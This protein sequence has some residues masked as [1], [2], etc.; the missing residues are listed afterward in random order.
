ML[1]IGGMFDVEITGETTERFAVDFDPGDDWRVGLIVGPSGSGKSTLLRELFGAPAEH[2]WRDDAAVVDDFPDMPARD[3]AW[4]LGNVGFNSP[5]SWFKPYRV[6]STGERFRVDVARALA[7]VEPGGVAVVDE[8]TSVVD[9]QV[10]KIA[11]HCAQKLARRSGKRMVAASCHYDVVD[12]LQPD[13]VLTTEDMAVARR[14]LQRRPGIELD[15]FEADGLEAWRVFGK[16]HYL[17]KTFQGAARRRTVV[18]EH[19]GRPVAMECNRVLVH[20][21]RKNLAVCHRLVVMPD[22]QGVGAGEAL[23]RW[24]GQRLWEQGLRYRV[25]SA[26]PGVA[27]NL[28]RSPR[29]ALVRRSSQS[30]GPGS[31]RRGMD[32]SMRRVAAMGQTRFTFSFEYRAPA[33]TASA[34]SAFRGAT[35]EAA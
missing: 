6:L 30:A 31:R 8:F 15:V 20:P 18:A 9:R 4:V 7:E 27:A 5:P 28:S 12:W 33:A 10:A 22:Y 26:H 16:H 25:V 17:S 13:W 21:S 23:A 2:A 35:G 11:S 29:W 32:A 34:D 24:V 14:R 3:L 19:E 1:Q